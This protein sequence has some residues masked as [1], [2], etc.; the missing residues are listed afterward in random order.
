METGILEKSGDV[1]VQATQLLD[2]GFLEANP[3]LWILIGVALA[4][5]LWGRRVARVKS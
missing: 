4:W 2:P 1:A 3:A 5:V